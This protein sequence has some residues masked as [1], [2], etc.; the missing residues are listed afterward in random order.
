[1]SRRGSPADLIDREQEVESGCQKVES[2][3]GGGTPCAK[4]VESNGFS[5]WTEFSAPGLGGLTIDWDLPW[6]RD[7]AP[8]SL[9]PGPR[10]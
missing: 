5:T 3:P 2:V 10:S 9:G 1:M 4:G 7:R 6:P 8:D